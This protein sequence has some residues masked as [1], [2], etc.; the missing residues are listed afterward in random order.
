MH[1][2]R[3]FRGL[4][5][6]IQTIRRSSLSR[7]LVV[8]RLLA[9][10]GFND[11]HVGVA[12]HT[13]TCG[14]E[15]T[16]DNVFLKTE[17]VV[18]LALDGSLGQHLCGLL[19]GCGGE[20]G[21][22]LER[23]LGDTE[24]YL[25]ALGMTRL[26]LALGYACIYLCVLILKLVDGNS[27]AGKQRRVACVVDAHFTRHLAGND[28]DVLIVDVNRLSTVNALG[29]ADDIIVN[30]VKSEDIHDIRRAL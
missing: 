7:C 4:L 15:L 11:I 13:C 2:A 20:E 14:N 8:H 21:L 5:L 23:R 6:I 1:N 25:L 16:D 28:L 27:G 12:L 10:L 24:Q 17:Q 9:G 30:G 3:F 22:G 26:G 29:L 18:D 19:E